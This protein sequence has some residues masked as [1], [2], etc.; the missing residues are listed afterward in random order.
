[1]YVTNLTDRP[2]GIDGIIVLKPYEENRYINDTGDLYIRVGK[3]CAA[4]LVSVSKQPGLVKEVPAEAVE[5]VVFEDKVIEAKPVADPVVEP[6]PVAEPVVE[7]KTT[8]SR[9]TKRG[10]K[11]D[12]QA[13]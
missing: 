9:T 1:M 5:E 4:K 3:L 8:K 11:N 10:A 12:V 2:V 13:E 6:E 7:A